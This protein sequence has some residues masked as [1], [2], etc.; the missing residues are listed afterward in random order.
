[1]SEEMQTLLAEI[2]RHAAESGF[3][4]STICREAVNDGGFARRLREGGQ[5]LP[6][7]ASKLRR[8]LAANPPETLRSKRRRRAA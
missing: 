1:M 6:A 2:E 3:A 5:C 4:A 8:W 7:T